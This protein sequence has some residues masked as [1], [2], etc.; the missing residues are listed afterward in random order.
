MGIDHEQLS[1][2]L[3]SKGF[4]KRDSGEWV[5][6][7]S[8]GSRSVTELEQNISP[9]PLVSAQIQKSSSQKFLVCVT[10]FRR[11]LID[12]DN[13]CEKYHV[14]LCRYSGCLPSDA[15]DQTQ[16]KVYQE[17]VKT[18]EEEFVEIKVYEL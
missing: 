7:P 18:K 1:V 8:Q 2:D 15:A 4:T 10:S 3:R 6:I 11:R 5:K 12:E 16:I 13:L 17:K 9:Q 14:D